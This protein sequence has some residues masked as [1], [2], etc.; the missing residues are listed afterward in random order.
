MVF[1]FRERIERL[2]L[3]SVSLASYIMEITLNGMNRNQ[4]A[5]IRLYQHQR[6]QRPRD[7]LH[8]N[9]HSPFSIFQPSYST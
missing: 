2:P 5:H 9:R 3:P 8:L 6:R 7:V 4:P 1:R